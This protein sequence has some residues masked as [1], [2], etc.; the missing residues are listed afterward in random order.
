MQL[1][2]LDLGAFEVEQLWRERL[3]I[4]VTSTYE[5]GTPPQNAR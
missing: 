1:S 4:I 5:D 3:V 2:V